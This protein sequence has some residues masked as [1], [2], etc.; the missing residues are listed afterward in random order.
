MSN[1]ACECD[2]CCQTHPLF[3]C[4]QYW[5]FTEIVLYWSAILLQFLNFW[6]S[7]VHQFIIGILMKQLNR[8]FWPLAIRQRFPVC[9][10]TL[11]FMWSIS[12]I[13]LMAF[14]SSQCV[15]NPWLLLVTWPL[16]LQVVWIMFVSCWHSLRYVCN[17]QIIWAYGSCVFQPQH[18]VLKSGFI[19]FAN[20]HPRYLNLCQSMLSCFIFLLDMHMSRKSSEIDRPTLVVYWC[21]INVIFNCNNM[22]RLQNMSTIIFFYKFFTLHTSALGSTI[23]NVP[24]AYLVSTY[25]WRPSLLAAAQ[26]TCVIFFLT[27]GVLVRV[28]VCGFFDLG[29]CYAFDASRM[30]SARLSFHWQFGTPHGVGLYI[31]LACE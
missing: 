10:E 25:I 20:S 27:H 12:F 6:A 31:Y 1:A 13:T 3:F 11:E 5:T 8:D 19:C 29:F 24:P 26:H 18:W 14:I 2:G 22:Y 15:G 30:L 16:C 28:L 23:I 4:C 17:I 21:S 9:L 7:R